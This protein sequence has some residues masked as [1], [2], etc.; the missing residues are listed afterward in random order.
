M[1]TSFKSESVQGRVC[2]RC[3]GN[4]YKREFSGWRCQFCGTVYPDNDDPENPA[5]RIPIPIYVEKRNEQR[6][7]AEG[8]IVFNTIPWVVALISFIVLVSFHYPGRFNETE[9]LL[10][11]VLIAGIVFGI[12][13]IPIIRAAKRMLREIDESVKSNRDD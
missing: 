13:G 3:G 8:E 12:R 4:E 7:K 9:L 2:P 5:P 11:V 6:Q 1:A 10:V